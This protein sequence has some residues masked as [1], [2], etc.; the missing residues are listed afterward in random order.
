MVIVIIWLAQVPGSVP[1][2]VYTDLQ[3]GG[4]LAQTDFYYRLIEL[5]VLA[6]PK[7]YLL[8]IKITF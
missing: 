5:A 4:L 6:A 1:G 3:N 8:F 2:G 7:L